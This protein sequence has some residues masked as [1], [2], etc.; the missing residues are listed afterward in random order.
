MSKVSVLQH[1]NFW[2]MNEYSDI[3]TVLSVKPEYCTI[4]QRN[5]AYLYNKKNMS[6]KQLNNIKGSKYKGFFNEVNKKSLMTATGWL[7]SLA[8]EKSIF[9]EKFNS[10]FKFRVN[11]ITL[12]LSAPQ[13]HDDL[14]IKRY[15]LNRFLVNCKRSFG[16]LNYIWRAEPQKNGNIH[17]HLLTDVYIHHSDLRSTWN[18]IQLDYGYINQ[19]NINS[20]PNSTDI[21]SLKNIKNV[22]QYVAKYCTKN[23]PTRRT[24][25]GKLYG[26]SKGLNKLKGCQIVLDNDKGLQLRNY[27]KKRKIKVVKKDFAMVIYST[28]KELYNSVKF[29]KKEVTDYIKHCFGLV[30]N[31]ILPK[32]INPVVYIPPI[33]KNNHFTYSQLNLL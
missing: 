28:V 7:I 2:L 21:H 3:S 11:F 13:M 8:K 20:N 33:K 6:E 10:W 12:T 15:M 24:I 23:D 4:Y 17:F 30:S 19:N 31:Y 14:F 25:K 22:S 18:N 16:M 29:V 32:A 9:N 1:L 5:E 26:I 27:L